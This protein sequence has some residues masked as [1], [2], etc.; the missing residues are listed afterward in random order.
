LPF[1]KMFLCLTMV[2]IVSLSLMTSGCK[3]A[4]TAS[5]DMM[6]LEMDYEDFQRI[7][8]SHG[9]DVEVEKA[10]SY[11][12]ILHIDEIL[13]EYLNVRKSGGTIYIGLKPNYIYSTQTRKVEIRLP[14]LRRLELSGASEGTV[15]GFTGMD[16]TD[17]EV[18]GAS[19][20]NIR[21][22]EARDVELNVSGASEVTGSVK[23]NKGLFDLS[24]GSRLELTGSASEISVE[25]SGASYVILTEY[26][27]VNADVKLSGSS[28]AEIVVSERLDIDLSGTSRLIYAGNP[29]LGRINVSDS[30]SIVQK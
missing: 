11:A 3:E 4:I 19:H 18:S 7:E 10:D 25:A 22:L 2:A 12:V 6:M 21:D 28:K 8:A 20:L 24:G 17:F 5:G 1:K 29:R 23:V 15:S 16:E 27:T 9:F 30:S 13:V 14:N 26:T